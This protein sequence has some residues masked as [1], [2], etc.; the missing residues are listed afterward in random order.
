[1]ENERFYQNRKVQWIFLNALSPGKEKRAMPHKQQQ[2]RMCQRVNH[3]HWSKL[4]LALGAYKC[5]RI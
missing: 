5:T 1:M 3:F 2:K 4:A